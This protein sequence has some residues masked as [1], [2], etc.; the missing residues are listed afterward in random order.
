M[1][2]SVQSVSL[3]LSM[4][5]ILKKL[6]TSEPIP[7]LWSGIK[8][9]SYGFIFG[10][11]KSGKTTLAENLGL[12]IVMKK[13]DYLGMPLQIGNYKVLF[14]SLEEFWQP[15]TERNAKQIKEC[16]S[17]DSELLKNYIVVNDLFPRYIDSSESWKILNTTIQGSG[18]DIVIIDSLTRLY[19]G[20]IES[21]DT[22]QTVSKKLREITN[23]NKI[24]LI[25]IHHTP[26]IAGRAI[27]MDSLAGS[28]VLAQEADFMIGV[29][30]SYNGSRYLK[31]VAFRYKQESE[32][33]LLLKL[34]ENLWFEPNCWINE[35]KLLFQ[36][37]GR[38]DSTNRDSLYQYIVDCTAS[39]KEVDTKT[40]VSYFSKTMGKTTIYD[41]INE[42]QKENLI[43]KPSK[44]KISIVKKSVQE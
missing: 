13:P 39:Q 3:T 2:D 35:Q 16:L 10:P 34:N 14:I 1:A 27:T 37:D 32:N 30:K 17:T 23:N 43:F 31:E 7:F 11:S 42:L 19:S 25:V 9:N 24:T 33:V 12:S 18:V 21:S 15:R 20:D 5:E 40:L 22:A 4:P 29:S 28:R 41:C 26:K 38:T 36:A 8:K 44:G 6:E